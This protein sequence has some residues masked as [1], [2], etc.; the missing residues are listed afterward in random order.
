MCRPVTIKL[1]GTGVI[2]SFG[3]TFKHLFSRGLTVQYPDEKLPIPE[4]SRGIL[5]WR[6]DL[7]IICLRCVRICPTRAI[8]MDVSK[9][10]ANK[11]H[12]DRYAIDYGRC[13]LCGL[14]QETCPVKPVKAVYHTPIYEETGFTRASMVHTNEKFLA[15]R[16]VFADPHVEHDEQ[17][18]QEETP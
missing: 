2:K 4:R 18:E 10:E 17:P 1:F 9:D 6:N 16:Q 11:R 15:L 3:V 7:C 12:V 5:I 13:Q 14:C 8:Q